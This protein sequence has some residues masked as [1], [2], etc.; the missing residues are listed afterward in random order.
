MLWERQ[1]RDRSSHLMAG[2]T[3]EAVLKKALS[4]LTKSWAPG[5]LL[6]RS[7][8]SLPGFLQRDH[9]EDEEGRYL[10]HQYTQARMKWSPWVNMPGHLTASSGRGCPPSS[11]HPGWHTIFK[12]SLLQGYVHLWQ[13]PCPLLLYIMG[14]RESISVGFWSTSLPLSSA[15]F[16][17]LGVLQLQPSGGGHDSFASLTYLIRILTW[18]SNYLCQWRPELLAGVSDELGLLGQC[19]ASLEVES[20]VSSGRGGFHPHSLFSPS[21][22]LESAA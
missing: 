17:N 4:L 11:P 5:V 14:W 10:V 12:S 3:E 15:A 13:T 22:T 21:L 8:T 1:D 7:S 2:E 20:W 6:P 19:L 16:N 9:S 18:D